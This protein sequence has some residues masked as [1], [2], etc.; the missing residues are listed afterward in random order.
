VLLKIKPKELQRLKKK[1]NKGA[2]EKERSIK[3]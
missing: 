2:E 3:K 1:D